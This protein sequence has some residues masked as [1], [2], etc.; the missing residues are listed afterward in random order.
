MMNISP[1][2]ERSRYT[3]QITKRR[4]MVS[5]TTVAMTLKAIQQSFD[6]LTKTNIPAAYARSAPITEI[7]SQPVRSPPAA[8]Q[9]RPDLLNGLARFYLD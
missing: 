3:I 2:L 6:I 9:A 4:L 1:V 8:L 5:K 7:H